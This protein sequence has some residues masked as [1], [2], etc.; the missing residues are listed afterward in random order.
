MYLSH[1]PNTTGV[2]L[3]VKCFLTLPSL[4][5]YPPSCVSSIQVHRRG[6]LPG[7]GGSGGQ[8]ERILLL[9]GQQH[10]YWWQ[11]KWYTPGLPNLGSAG[12]RQDGGGW[13]DTTS[14]SHRGHGRQGQGE[15][16]G[17]LVETLKWIKIQWFLYR[18]VYVILWIYGAML[19][20]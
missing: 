2:D 16:K 20:V 1:R 10:S 7:P 12:C 8:D 18:R 19:M 13:G 11:E 4:P 17:Q 15:F 3:P 5:V 14:T 6:L 9:P